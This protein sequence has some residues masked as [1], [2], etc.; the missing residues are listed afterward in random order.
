MLSVAGLVSIPGMMTGQILAGGDA[1]T[2]AKYQIMIMFGIAAS[3]T[4]ATII[5]VGVTLR[6]L[7]D[8]SHRLR[9]DRLIDRQNDVLYNV[10]YAPGSA[11]AQKCFRILV[12]GC[13]HF[14][15][16]PEAASSGFKA[17]TAFCIHACMA[18][19]KLADCRRLHTPR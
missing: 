17:F 7:M 12:H 16:A 14:L 6:A 18:Q 3:S 8:E 1:V 5:A 19:C 15:S 11:F 2:A 4:S 9:V 13:I 10:W